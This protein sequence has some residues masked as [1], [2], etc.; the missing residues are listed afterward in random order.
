MI[1]QK[2]QLS[3]LQ[4]PKKLT[5]HESFI[6]NLLDPVKIEIC[7]D[8]CYLLSPILKFNFKYSWYQHKMQILNQLLTL[9]TSVDR[10]PLKL[11]EPYCIAKSVPFFL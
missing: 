10:N 7:L 11:P 2:S 3:H 9:T 4:T 6:E 5:L 1:R 8:K